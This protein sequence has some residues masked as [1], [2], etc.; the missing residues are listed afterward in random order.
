MLKEKLNRIRMN[1]EIIKR[2]FSY[3]GTKEIP[4]KES[5]PAVL[6]MI[7]SL[8]SWVK[9]DEINW[10]SAFAKRV[11]EEAGYDSSGANA[12]AR[13]WL[14]VGEAVAEPVPGDI[15]VF[16][17]ISKLDWRGHVGF[18]LHDDGEDIWVLGGNQSD[19]VNVSPYSKSRLLA[20]RRPVKL[21]T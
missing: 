20:Y 8:L 11:V 6:A 17:R 7:Q 14:N 18:F 4:G 12:A 2:A 10:C 19:E 21:L 15:V 13:S 5:N 1:T 9:N 16:W 3:L